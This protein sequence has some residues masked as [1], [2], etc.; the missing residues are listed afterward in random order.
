MTTPATLTGKCLCETVRFELTAPCR[1]VIVCHCGQCAR[2]TGYAVAAT[3]VGV[4]HFRFLAGSDAVQWY[5]ASDQA[6]RGFCRICGSS[7][8]WKP[9][10]GTRISVLAGTLAGLTGLTIGAHIHVAEK[11]DFTEIA[12]GPP[13]YPGGSIGALE[14]PRAGS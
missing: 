6:E 4:D 12:A 13:Q 10:D 8:F 9:G 11:P 7:L 14:L 1:A 3:A 5:R 2:W